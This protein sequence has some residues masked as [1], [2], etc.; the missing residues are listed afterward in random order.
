MKVGVSLKVL[1]LINSFGGLYNFRR[2]FIQRLIDKNNQVSISGPN[3]ELIDYFIEIGCEVIETPFDSRGTNL[4]N[5]LKLFLSYTKLLKEVNPD[6]VLTYTIKP[7]IYGGFACHMKG[8]PCLSTI[9]GLGTAIENPSLLQKVLLILYRFSLNKAKTV[10]FQNNENQKFLHKKNI[11]VHN[12]VLVPGSGVNLDYFQLLEYPEDQIIRFLFIGR[13]MKEKGIDQFLK[14][15]TYIKTHYHNTEFHIIGRC[16]EN[17][18]NKLKD[19]E[20]KGIIK[21]H[22]Q[23]SDVRKFHERSHCTI[24]P[25]YYP[26]GMSNVLLESAA[27][28]RPVITTDRSG[29]REIVDHGVN[30]YIVEQKNSHDLIKKIEKFLNLPHEQKKNMGLAGRRKVEKEFD[31]QIVVNAYMNQ[32]NEL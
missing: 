6:V 10:F 21:Y 3:H 17:Y 14:A 31:R 25:T 30:G 11:A 16:D 32:I 5:D 19:L 23:Q 2:E 26:E 7:N 8:I 28:G 9:T 15:T 1:I 29:C 13:V 24:H 20:K 27:S 18:L 12:S 4:I 22:S